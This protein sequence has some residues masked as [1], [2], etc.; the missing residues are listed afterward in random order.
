M[1]NTGWHLPDIIFK[2]KN[3]NFKNVKYRK[4]NNFL[5]RTIGFIELKYTLC[6]PTVNN[7]VEW[8]TSKICLIGA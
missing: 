5:I 6:C 1:D 3:K 2:T 7:K 4:N 8:V